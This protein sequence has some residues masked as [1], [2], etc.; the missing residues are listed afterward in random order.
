MLGLELRMLSDNSLLTPSD[1]KFALDKL[2]SLTDRMYEGEPLGLF[3]MHQ[4]EAI[5]E[6]LEKSQRGYQQ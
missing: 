5:R 3:W 2:L 6:L 1:Y 4:T